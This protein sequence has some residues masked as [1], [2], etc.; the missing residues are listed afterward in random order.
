MTGIYKITN[1]K[2]IYYDTLSE[3]SNVVGIS[4]SHLSAK[5]NGIKKNNTN[6][7]YV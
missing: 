1:P 4:K 6:L 5:L 2:G 3:A 7:I